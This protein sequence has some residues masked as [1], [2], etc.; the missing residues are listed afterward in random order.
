MVSNLKANI[1]ILITGAIISLVILLGLNL[2]LNLNEFQEA[3]IDL[4]T[5]IASILIFLFLGL[6]SGNIKQKSG[7]VNG[8]LFSTVFVVI[9]II[10]SIFT[11]TLDFSHIVR[12]I[13]MILTGGLG[14][15]IGVNF[16]PIVK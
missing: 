7:L 3:K 11:K 12:Y 4:F 16:K 15:I 14:G 2:I 1:M 8:V 13:I 10:I 5:F 6:L 9:F